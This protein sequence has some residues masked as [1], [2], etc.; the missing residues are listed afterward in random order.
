MM[1]LP[2]RNWGWGWMSRVDVDWRAPKLK[3]LYGMTVEQYD[4][5]LEAQGGGCAV[6]G[7]GTQD[8][9]RLH[10]DHDHGCCPGRRSCGRCIRGI[11]C[12]ACNLM[13]G[14]AND[15]PALLLKGILY[16]DQTR[17]RLKDSLVN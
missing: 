13:L 8:G 15:D 10:V 4:A 11:L 16:L 5:M 2:W 7:G 1:R 6:C 3:S 12:R 17:Q 9:R 14:N